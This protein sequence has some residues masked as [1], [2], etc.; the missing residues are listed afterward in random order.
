LDCWVHHELVGK[1]VRELSPFKAI[2]SSRTMLEQLQQQEYVRY[3][4]LTLETKQGRQIVVELVSNIYQ[5]GD[6]KWIQC[7]L[8]DVTARKKSEPWLTLLNTCV[9]NLND[10]V[11]ITEATPVDEWGPRIV[12]VNEGFE[13]I[14]GYTS[15]EIVGRS[16]RFLGGKK[17]DRRILAEIQT[18]SGRFLATPLSCTRFL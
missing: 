7:N 4:N 5:A 11:L 12:F 17:T 16:P 15:A 18:R 14:T 8:R 1:T 13:R 6:K 3:E 9:A 2:E 10:I